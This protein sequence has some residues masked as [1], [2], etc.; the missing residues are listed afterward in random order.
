M[1]HRSANHVTQVRS[2]G[3]QCAK[4]AGSVVLVSTKTRQERICVEIVLQTL[5][6][7]SMAPQLWMI[8]FHAPLTLSQMVQGAR[9]QRIA[10][11][12]CNTM[13]HLP[14]ESTNV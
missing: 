1:R 10:S 6:I 12:V 3:M 8:A 5:T 2:A 11:A 13:L 14:T 9:H 4:C 7:P